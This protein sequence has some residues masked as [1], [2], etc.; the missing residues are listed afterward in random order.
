MTLR[1]KLKSLTIDNVICFFVGIVLYFGMALI[2]NYQ[3][4]STLFPLWYTLLLIGFVMLM[5]N[6]FVILNIKNLKRK[7]YYDMRDLSD[8]KIDG[9]DHGKKI[10]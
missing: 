3:I 9:L 6:L 1:Q 8:G 5:Y 4:L 2:L 7:I 10:K